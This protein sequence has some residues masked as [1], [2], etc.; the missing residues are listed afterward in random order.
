MVTT[1]DIVS[2]GRTILGVGAGWHKEE[3][4]SYGLPWSN[5]QIRID[6]T[7]ECL[8]IILKLWKEERAAF[9]GKY[10]K[11]KNAPFWPKP[12][13]QPHPQIFFGGNNPNLLKA[14]ARHGNGWVPNT[15]M[16][17]KTFKKNVSIIEE[18]AEKIKKPLSDIKYAI[19]LS[20]PNGLGKEP[21][22]WIQNTKK[23]FEDGATQIILD[24]SGSPLNPQETIKFLEK[25]TQ[26]VIT[27]F[28]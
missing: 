3:A 11:I 26:R 15:N 10:Y 8:K 5:L 6:K 18:E 13:Q 27:E 22:E 4:V 28:L 23:W 17:I 16:S 21:V 7:M 2:K 19:A 9:K 20:Y 1:V 25:F 24:I 14:V 12:V